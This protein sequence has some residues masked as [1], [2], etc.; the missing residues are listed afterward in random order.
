MAKKVKDKL[1]L[2]NNCKVLSKEELAFMNAKYN[3]WISGD[4][5]CVKCMNRAR[6]T[7]HKKTE[8]FSINVKHIRK[9]TY[10]VTAIQLFEKLQTSDSTRDYSLT[11]IQN[12]INICRITY[13]PITDEQILKILKTR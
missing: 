2:A 7:P 11:D 10:S 8:K 4:Y 6:V 5:I 12:A 1:P 13:Q 3:F 9:I